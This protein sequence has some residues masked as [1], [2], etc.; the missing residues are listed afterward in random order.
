MNFRGKTTVDLSYDSTA[1]EMKSALEALDTIGK[2]HVMREVEDSA[3]KT[4]A[5]SITF[6]TPPVPGDQPMLFASGADLIA[7]DGDEDEEEDDD[8]L[9]IMTA[10]ISVDEERRGRAKTLTLGNQSAMIHGIV[11]DLYPGTTYDLKAVLNDFDCVPLN[12]HEHNFTTLPRNGVAPPMG[13][14]LTAYCSSNTT[15]SVSATDSL[16]CH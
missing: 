9:E 11:E 7:I 12:T 4:Y 6:A 13:V 1:S 8:S 2:V 14:S 10:S 5:W 16:P 15:V 3:A